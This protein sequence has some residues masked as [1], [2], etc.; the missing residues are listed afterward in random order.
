MLS[1]VESSEAGEIQ[2]IFRT[3]KNQL[4]PIEEVDAYVLSLPRTDCAVMG[5]TS[6]STLTFR[7]QLVTSK[8]KMYKI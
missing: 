2:A 1:I 4:A 5:K 6:I 3:D 8:N 7:E